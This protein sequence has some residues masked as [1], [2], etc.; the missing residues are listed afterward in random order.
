MSKHIWSRNKLELKKYH[1]VNRNQEE[2]KGEQDDSS[3]GG[4]NTYELHQD[5]FMKKYPLA[6]IPTRNDVSI[7]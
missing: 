1:G 6:G 5:S 4:Q 2:D 3:I 7:K